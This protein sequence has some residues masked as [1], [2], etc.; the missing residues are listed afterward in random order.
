MPLPPQDP[1]HWLLALA[2]NAVLISLAQRAPLLTRA[3]WVHAGLLG[4]LLWGS[5]GWRGW[6]AV[7]AYLALG[8]LVTK[9]GFRTKQAAGLAEARGGRRGPE[10]VWGSAATG[11][12]LALLRPLLPAPWT[13]LL[14]VGFAASFAAK[15]ADTFGSEIGKRW[16]RTTVLITSLR[17]VPRGTEGAISLEG[18]AAS[19]AGGTVMAACCW[20]LGLLADGRAW[21]LVSAVALLA[22]LLESLIGATLQ[23]RWRWLSNELVNGLQ[24]LI[25]ALLA[26]ALSLAPDAGGL[27]QLGQ[28]GVVAPLGHARVDVQ[29]PA[30]LHPAGSLQLAADQQA[31]QRGLQGGQLVGQPLPLPR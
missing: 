28:A 29:L 20:A 5:L 22:T 7:V 8:S 27:L 10:N 14:L 19:L 3:G 11:A 6:L 25:A 24:T 31:A 18:T 1:G 15:L 16:G 21:A 12:A 23:R 17:P 4:T 2:L 26:I 30:Q 13:P 9:L